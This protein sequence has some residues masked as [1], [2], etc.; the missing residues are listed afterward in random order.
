MAKIVSVVL[1]LEDNEAWELAQFVKRAGW[2][3]FRTCAVD[4]EEAYIIRD[5]VAKL[6]KALAEAGYAPR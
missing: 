5:S 2:E 1:D 6:A 4:D 3:H